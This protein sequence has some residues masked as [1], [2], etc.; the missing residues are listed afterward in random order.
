MEVI[1]VSKPTREYK[2]YPLHQ[3][4]CWEILFSMKGKGKIRINK[5]VVPFHEGSIFCIP[6]MTP[7]CKRSEEGYADG[8]IFAEQLGLSEDR[9]WIFEDDSQ[10]TLTS[11]F[12]IAY[13]TQMR[14]SPNSKKII[15]A[16]GDAIY[17]M[18]LEMS[19]WNGT[20]NEAVDRFAHLLIDKIPDCSFDI[21]KA[22]EETGYNPNYFRKIFRDM[23]NTTPVEYFNRLRIEHA[24]RQLKQYGTIRS[25]KEISARCGFSDP[26]YFSRKFKQLTGMSPRDFLKTMETI[27]EEILTWTVVTEEEDPEHKA[28]NQW[29]DISKARG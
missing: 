10:G 12:E 5:L 18:L 11:L 13:T 21:S 3:H 16:L 4:H 26:Y 28:R 6:P 29:R 8:C 15:D 17:Q 2:D 14:N 25:I 23:L 22:V 1:S 20:R 9:V 24:K 7:H 19:E 27:D